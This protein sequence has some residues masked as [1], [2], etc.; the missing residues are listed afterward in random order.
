MA[1]HFLGTLTIGQAPRADITPILNAHLPERVSLHLGVLDGLS[2]EE[3]AARFTPR[4]GDAVLTTRLLDGSSVVLGKPA[5]RVVLQEKL[6]LLE[7]HGCSLIVLLC[8]GEF[9][10][11][12]CRKAWLIEPD[13][14]VPPVVASLVNSHQVGVVVPLPAQ[15]NSEAR[16]W[17]PLART[18]LYAVASPYADGVDAVARAALE[19]KSR[20]AEILLFDCMGFTERHREVAREASGLP[21][22]L[23]NALVARLLAELV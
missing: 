9:E 21:V 16:K 14:L 13:H 7:A 10:G 23:S 6:D 19:L 2:K 17:Q 11:L 4:P 22:L 18:P 5:V 8:T 3:I 12:A 1:A 15:M 20:G